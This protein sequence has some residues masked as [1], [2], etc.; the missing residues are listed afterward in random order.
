M[1]ISASPLLIGIAAIALSASFTSGC[2]FL[3]SIVDNIS[4]GASCEEDS[5]CLGGM[6]LTDAN[7]FPDGYCTTASCE[8]NG[9]T[10]IFGSECL[11]IL[12]ALGPA[13]YETCDTDRPCRDGYSCLTVE[14]E[15]V[16]LPTVLE[17]RFPTE[18]EIG[19]RRAPIAMV[20]TAS[21]T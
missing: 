18:G 21:P 14:S 6:C 12:D 10:N 2:D 5:N 9:C 20:A 17:A 3:N 11:D 7:G 8:Q 1:R 16:C 13:C 15:R 19:T 4:D